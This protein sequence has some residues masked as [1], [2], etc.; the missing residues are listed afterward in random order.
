MR[1]FKMEIVTPDRHYPERDVTFLDVPAEQGRLTVL[2]GHEP[3]IC[4]LC[5]G[6]L[7]LRVAPPVAAG[8]AQANSARDQDGAAGAPPGGVGT[9][10]EEAW[11][12]GSG[13]MKVGSGRVVLLVRTAEPAPAA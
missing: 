9:A 3:L 2:A 11:R 12:I 5:D 10:A 4:G 1:S 8:D 6:L 13:T 7:R